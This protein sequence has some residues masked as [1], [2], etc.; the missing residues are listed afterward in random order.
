MK[1]ARLKRTHAEGGPWSHQTQTQKAS[2]GGW[3][4]ESVFHGNRV[5]IRKLK[6]SRGGWWGGLHDTMI[7]FRVAEQSLRRG[8]GEKLIYPYVAQGYAA[9]RPR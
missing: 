4:G 2:P 6:L 9:A 1:E 5:P 7:R 3:G 8:Q